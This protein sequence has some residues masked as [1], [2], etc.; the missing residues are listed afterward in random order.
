MNKNRLFRH[1][2][3]KK[4]EAKCKKEHFETI[5]EYAQSLLIN[6]KIWKILL[7]TI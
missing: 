2:L 1:T 5:I 6:T 7:A 4:E 3:F